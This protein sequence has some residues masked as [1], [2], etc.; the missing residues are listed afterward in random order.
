MFWNIARG[1]GYCTKC[2]RTFSDKIQVLEN[3][4]I[5]LLLLLGNLD[6]HNLVD[7]IYVRVMVDPEKS[8][9]HIFRRLG[10]VRLGL[11]RLSTVTN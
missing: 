4:F 5:C 11:R 9:S 6:H 10:I 7:E 1:H 3:G 2:K 8:T